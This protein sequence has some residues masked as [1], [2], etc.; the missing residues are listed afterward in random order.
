MI[1]YIPLDSLLPSWT[2]SQTAPSFPV[3]D[4][5]VMRVTAPGRNTRSNMSLQVWVLLFLLSLLSL[6][7]E[8]LKD[9]PYN[10]SMG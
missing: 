4:G 9:L 6:P 10:R 5:H 7:A 3:S 1:L 2:Y 8:V